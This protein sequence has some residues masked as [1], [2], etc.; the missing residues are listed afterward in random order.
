MF[1]RDP[2]VWFKGHKFFTVWNKFFVML[3]FVLTVFNQ[4]HVDTKT[5]S[6][7][8]GKTLTNVELIEQEKFIHKFLRHFQPCVVTTQT[9]VCLVF[10]TLLWNPLRKNTD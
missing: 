1:L 3:Y 8:I 6:K 10:W 9:L 2:V 4:P 7:R 5:I